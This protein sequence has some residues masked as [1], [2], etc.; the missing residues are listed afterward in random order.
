MGNGGSKS[1]NSVEVYNEAVLNALVENVTKCFDNVAAGQ[2]ITVDCHPSDAMVKA[3]ADSPA[4]RAAGTWWGMLLGADPSACK[5]CVIENVDQQKVIELKAT[6]QATSVTKADVKNAITNSLQQAA[7]AAATGVT[8]FTKAES[9]NIANYTSKIV[10]NITTKNITD[11]I[12]NVNTS[13]QV[14]VTGSGGTAK[15]ITQK[16]AANIA[17]SVLSNNQSYVSAVNDLRNY[18]DQIAKSKAT[19]PI[20]A[21]ADALMAPYKALAEAFGLAAGAGGV[22]SVSSSSSASLACLCCCLLIILMVF[23]EILK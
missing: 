18:I 3:Y 23:S 7:K 12:T 19:G 20:V 4:C 13:Q 15:G 9:D 5:A 2:V 6:C 14:S 1:T 16:G 21:L 10:D 17:T 11:M 22:I 8:A